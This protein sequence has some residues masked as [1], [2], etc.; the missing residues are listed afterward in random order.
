MFLIVIIFI[1]V[2][3]D[4]GHYINCQSTVLDLF[5]ILHS[6]DNRLKGLKVGLVI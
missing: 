1:N 2:V 4:N 5:Q 3:M 6:Y